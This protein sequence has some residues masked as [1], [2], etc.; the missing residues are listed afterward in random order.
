MLLCDLISEVADGRVDSVGRRQSYLSCKCLIEEAM[1]LWTGGQR[2][3]RWMT[4]VVSL[5]SE[6]SVTAPRVV[7]RLRHADTKVSAVVSIKVQ[8]QTNSGSRGS[9]I[10][11][12]ADVFFC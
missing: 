3:P 11:F 8:L 10:R 2:E 1:R 6:R 7:G 5:G 12:N 9:G 4:D